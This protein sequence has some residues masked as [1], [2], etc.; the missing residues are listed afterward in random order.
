MC[1]AG[2]MTQGC[3]RVALRADGAMVSTTI[4]LTGRSSYLRPCKSLPVTPLACMWTMNLMLYCC[5]TRVGDISSACEALALSGSKPGHTGVSGR[6]R[7]KT[8]EGLMYINN[9]VTPCT[10]DTQRHLDRGSLH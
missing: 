2:G 10:W 5:A 4:L 9:D 8:R 3:V 6:R 7:T 1:G